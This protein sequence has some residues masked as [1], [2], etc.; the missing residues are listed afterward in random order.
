MQDKPKKKS[1]TTELKRTWRGTGTWVHDLFKLKVTSFKKNMS[2]RKYEPNLQD[3]EHVHFFHTTDRQGKPLR[4]CA[5]IGGHYHEMEVYE[6]NGELKAKCG[7]PKR[8]VEKKLRNG[9]TEK[10]VEPVYFFDGDD[11]RKVYD[12]HSHEVEYLGSEMISED[13]I[14]QTEFKD[15]AK[16]EALQSGYNSHQAKSLPEVDIA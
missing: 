7:P 12:T 2:Y 13:K 3:V 14:K 10:K 15:K 16:L 9:R 5:P 1:S 11:D 6:E 4:T 8:I